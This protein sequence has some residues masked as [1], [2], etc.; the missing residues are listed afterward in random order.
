MSIID[1]RVRVTS[2][3]IVALSCMGLLADTVRPGLVQFSNGDTV[4]GSFTL[5][6]G[7]E[8]KIHT[9]RE[10]KTV[11]ISS[12]R[13]MAFEPEKESLEQKWRFVEAGRTQKEKWGRPYPIR[14]IR[15]ILSLA[16][17]SVFRGY[18]YTTVLYLEGKEQTTKVVLR[19]KDRGE[20]G[21]TFA[22]LVYPVRIAF[23]D[24]G[25]TQSDAMT[26]TVSAS[27]ATELVALT[28]G[29]L[30][31]IP[32]VRTPQ[33]F[34][35]GGL[36]ATNAYMATRSD[37]GISVAWPAMTDTG[38]V[39]RIEQALGLVEDFFDSRELLGVQRTGDDVYSLLMLS[40]KNRTTLDR[41]NSQPWRLEVW[42]WKDNGDALMLA[43]RGYFFRGIVRKGG[44]PPPV[45]LSKE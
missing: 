8:L 25:L 37:A 11:S 1:N 19:A 29:A 13:E 43:G 38:L 27:N 18:L 6:P 20:E 24:T 4:E 33:G 32:A 17:G 10:L 42:R 45:I 35:L 16:D 7:S 3:L 36:T 41:E 9:G 30:L 44:T 5:T 39:T 23:A 40:R 34:R 21:Q 31:R 26:V 28:P 15:S 22:D 12:V 2:L 14:E